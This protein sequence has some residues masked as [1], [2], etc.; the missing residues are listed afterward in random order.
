MDFRNAVFKVGGEGGGPLGGGGSGGVLTIVGI[1]SLPPSIESEMK[2]DLAGGNGRFP[3][4]GGGGG[5][6][7]IYQGRPASADDVRDG[8]A[9]PLFF[10]V[11]AAQVAEGLLSVLGAGWDHIWV[12]E[13]PYRPSINVA[14]TAE[15][16]SIDANTLLGLEFAVTNPSGNLCGTG[17]ADLAVPEPTGAI[18]RSSGCASLAFDA[19]GPGTYELAVLSGGVRFA[20]YTFE[21]RLR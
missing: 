19:E 4:G 16:G 13:F 15:F 14:Y 18:N 11:N 21:V 10:P 7:L 1:A 3:G 9:V 2:I 5:G 6:L 20:R 17:T 8:L 12:L